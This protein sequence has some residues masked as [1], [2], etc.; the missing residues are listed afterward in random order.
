MVERTY[1]KVND[2]WQ[3]IQ[4]TWSSQ[5]EQDKS[6]LIEV[7]VCDYCCSKMKRKAKEAIC[8]VQFWAAIIAEA[9]VFELKA[10]NK[11]LKTIK[12]MFSFY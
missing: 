11:A 12:N 8:G 9:I 1:A 5:E 3:V 2:E 4:D 7:V 10:V 6:Y